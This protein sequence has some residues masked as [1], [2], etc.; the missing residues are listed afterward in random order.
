MAFVSAYPPPAPWT[1]QDLVLF[2]GTIDL[3]W[4]NPLTDPITVAA[5]RSSTDFGRGFYT[6]T[7]LPQARSWTY[8][9][10]RRRRG[11]SP[12]VLE[13]TLSRDDLAGLESVWFV[14][15]DWQA[16]DYWSLVRHC[17]GGRDHARAGIR[18]WYDAAVG[19]LASTW[20]NRMTFLNADQ[21]SFH[22]PDSE[23]LL[24]AA[25]RRL[26]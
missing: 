13:F 14:R 25:P 21:I 18:S 15:G 6:T 3:V 11:S 4:T 19:P 10:S 8:Q 9:M 17:R 24:N 12:L 5:G 23:L 1:N 16:D 2:H 20:Q 7:S 26:V 22:T